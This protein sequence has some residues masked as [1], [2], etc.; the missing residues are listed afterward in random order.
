M[1][2]GQALDDRQRA[3]VEDARSATLATIAPDGRPRLVPICFVV[4]GVVPG[5][6]T[7]IHSPIDEKPKGT[8]DPWSLARVRDLIDRPH[9]AILVERWSE[10]WSQ[11]GWL[12]LEVRGEILE[13]AGPDRAEHEAV[14]AALRAK[15]PQ[16]ATHQLDDRP[17]LSFTVERAVAW[18]ALG[19]S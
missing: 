12:R 18:G 11:L 10:D 6:A 2:H 15:Y 9:A 17:I 13:P 16:Y 4:G 5:Q 8:T 7:R 1:T 19:A 14:V 3:F